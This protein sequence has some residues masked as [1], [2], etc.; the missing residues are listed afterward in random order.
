MDGYEL[1][2]QFAAGRA[3][4]RSS[5]AQTSEPATHRV[6]DG[7]V[8]EDDEEI[9]QLLSTGNGR[10]SFA[11]DTGDDDKVHHGAA[12]SSGD[13]GAAARDQPAD[14]GTETKSLLA[15]FTGGM[16][17]RQ[18]RTFASEMLREVGEATVTVS[19]EWEVLTVAAGAKRRS[20]RSCSSR[21]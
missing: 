13:S 5:D 15:R 18:R 16:T 2:D 10:L 21:S 14:N 17:A 19:R 20:S 12:G 11:D 4:R 7:G 9:E 1:A 6:L 3:R 8:S